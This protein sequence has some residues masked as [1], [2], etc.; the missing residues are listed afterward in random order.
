MVSPRDCSP[1]HG[2]SASPAALPPSMRLPVGF[3]G[4]STVSEKEKLSLLMGVWSMSEDKVLAQWAG[5]P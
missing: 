2:T 4:D 1:R 3:G 5:V